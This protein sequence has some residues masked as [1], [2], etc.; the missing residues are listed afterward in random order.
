MIYNSLYLDPIA[1]PVIHRKQNHGIEQS[2]IVKVETDKLKDAQFIIELYYPD[3]VANVVLVQK[4]NGK[5]RVC[6]DFIDLNKVCPKN[7]YPLLLVDLLVDLITRHELLSIMD[8][9][10]G[11]NQIKKY[12]LDMETTSF[13]IDRGTYCYKVMPFGLKNVEET[14]Q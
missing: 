4:K 14:Y 3:W 2:N 13:V 9:Y 12:K 7:L 8:A 6:V 10:L 11:Y 1:K 5:C